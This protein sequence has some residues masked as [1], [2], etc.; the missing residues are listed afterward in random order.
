MNVTGYYFYPSNFHPRS[1]QKS[2]DVPPR[3]SLPEKCEKWPMVE[4]AL[5]WAGRFLPVPHV[6][7]PRDPKLSVHRM[8]RSVG[9][10]P[11]VFRRCLI[12]ESA[13]P[14][15]DSGEATAGHTNLNFLILT[16]AWF[17]PKF[18]YYSVNF[19]LRCVVAS[20]L[21]PLT[22]HVRWFLPSAD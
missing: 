15:G 17:V 16:A 7:L 1:V 12:D 9:F 6:I 22:I 13:G 4:L 2:P 14:W 8:S 3:E 20:Q 18:I 21:L 5:E 11:G 10:L 19:Y